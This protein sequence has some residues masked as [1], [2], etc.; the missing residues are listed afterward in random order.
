MKPDAWTRRSKLYEAYKTWCA[1]SER[2]SVN[3]QSFNT[4][5]RS[6]FV[7]RVTER[8][9]KGIRGWLGVKLVG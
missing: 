8:I 3:V 1:A 2:P 4:E 7:G 9:R 6:R 5:I